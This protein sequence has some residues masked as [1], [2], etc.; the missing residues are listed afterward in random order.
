MMEETI[1][2]SFKLRIKNIFVDGFEGHD[3]E[4]KRLFKQE[5][6]IRDKIALKDTKL[7]INDIVLVTIEVID[8]TQIKEDKKDEEFYVVVNEITN[9][10]FYTKGYDENVSRFKRFF[11]Y[12]TRGMITF[13]NAKYER[14]DVGDILKISIGGW[15]DGNRNNGIGNNRAYKC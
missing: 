13:T 12:E 6:L 1:K 10:G 11:W 14:F 15:L 9:N 8:K 3:L 4:E 2:V 5:S 7:K